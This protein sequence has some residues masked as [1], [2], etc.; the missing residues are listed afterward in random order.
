MSGLPP[1]STVVSIYCR[2]YLPVLS[3]HCWSFQPISFQLSPRNLSH[4]RF[5]GI[6][7]DC[8]CPLTSTAAYFNSFSWPSEHPFCLSPYLTYPS[9]SPHSPFSHSPSSEGSL[10]VQLCMGLLRGVAVSSHRWAV[11]CRSAE[12][13]KRPLSL[14]Q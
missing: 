2:W 8:P 5:L 9:F 4:P 13:P 7:R 10:G 6:S 12:P 11:R 14:L 3:L 1:A